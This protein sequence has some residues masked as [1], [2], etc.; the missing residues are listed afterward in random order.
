MSFLILTVSFIWLFR[1]TWLLKNLTTKM[2]I[3]LSKIS[4]MNG[5][6]IPIYFML[7]KKQIIQI[8]YKEYQILNCILSMQKPSLIMSLMH[9]KFF[10][11]HPI[12]IMMLGKKFLEV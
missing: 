1:N 4:T 3:Y 6:L 9:L 11:Q 5:G 8:S 2:M 7:G 12:S 10:L